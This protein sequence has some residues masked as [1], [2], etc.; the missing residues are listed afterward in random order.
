MTI[1]LQDSPRA[2]YNGAV[3]GSSASAMC[4]PSGGEATVALGPQLRD[5]RF[6]CAVHAEDVTGVFLHLYNAAG[7][8]KLSLACE[9]RNGMWIGLVALID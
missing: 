4:G 7:G 1:R 2:S 6:S 9:E 3:A 8:Y 5:G